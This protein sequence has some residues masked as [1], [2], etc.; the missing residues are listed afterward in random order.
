MELFP[1]RSV[2]LGKVPSRESALNPMGVMANYRDIDD[3]PP[4]IGR[5]IAGKA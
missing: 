1:G 3:V 5:R 2:A 4:A